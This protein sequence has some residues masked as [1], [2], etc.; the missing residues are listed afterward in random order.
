MVL[1]D[2]TRLSVEPEAFRGALADEGVLVGYI[3]PGVL[4]FV[5]HRNVDRADVERVAAVAGRLS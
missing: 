2:G 4:R 3:R 5:T 1:V